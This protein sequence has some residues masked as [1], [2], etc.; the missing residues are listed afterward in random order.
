M[1]STFKD[2]DSYNKIMAEEDPSVIKKLGKQVKNFDQNVWNQLKDDVMEKALKEKFDQ[3]A[4]IRGKL[5]ST[6]GKMI[7]E[8]TA[9]DKYWGT[10]Q[11]L[12]S[13]FALDNTTWTGQNKLG[14][15]LMQIRDN[16]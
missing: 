5:L 9:S 3:N 2:T 6:K 16:Y 7:G 11:N 13:K 15:L 10:G 8:A 14:K 1:A 4:F 12:F